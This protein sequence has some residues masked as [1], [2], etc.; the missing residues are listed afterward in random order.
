MSWFVQLSDLHVNRYTHADIVPDLMAF[1][2]QVLSRLRP[3][4]LLIT[5]DLVDAKTRAE[6]SKQHP[7]E[8]Q[9]WVCG[10][11]GSV[12]GGCRRGEGRG[13]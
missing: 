10:C 2:D 4:A 6:G 9:V 5:G 12:C 1:G 7:Q 3:Q 13:C 11:R 8:W